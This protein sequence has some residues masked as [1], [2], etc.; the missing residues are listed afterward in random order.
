MEGPL[1]GIG[2]PLRRQAASGSPL[3][4]GLK[5]RILG[6]FL[7]WFSP[8]VYTVDKNQ[9]IGTILPSPRLPS[10][11]V[12]QTIS[13]W[14]TNPYIVKFRVTVKFWRCTKTVH[15][16]TTTTNCIFY[17]HRTKVQ[18][19]L[20]LPYP[21]SYLPIQ[22]SQTPGCARCHCVIPVTTHWQPT[23]FHGDCTTDPIVCHSHYGPHAYIYAYY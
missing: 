23:V 11:L 7:M 5:C 17:R 15:R 9:N 16:I 10:W 4:R 18:P 2:N 21:S 6:S 13:R 20:V 8:S 3:S 19:R 1:P 14:H 22:E 12:L